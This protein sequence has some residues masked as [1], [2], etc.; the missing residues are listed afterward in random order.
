MVHTFTDEVC[1]A[2]GLP[3][4]HHYE[5]DTQDTKVCVIYTQTFQI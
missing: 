1:Q 5:F 3:K 2:P 4:M